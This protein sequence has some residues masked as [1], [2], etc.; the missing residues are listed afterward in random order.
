MSQDSNKIRA[1]DFIPKMGVTNDVE[2]YLYAIETTAHRE[3]W[4]KEQ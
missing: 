4:P 1:S 3:K 2:A